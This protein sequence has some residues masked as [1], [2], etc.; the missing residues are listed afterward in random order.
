MARIVGE[1]QPTYVWVENSPILVVRGLERVLWDLAALGYDARWGIVSAENAGAPHKRERCWIMAYAKG[2]S[3]NGCS[4]SKDSRGDSN[5]KDI[6]GEWNN[7]RTVF[8]AD[9]L[10]FVSPAK[11]KGKSESGLCL[12][13]DGVAGQ[14]DQLRAIG[15]GQVPAVVR[16]AWNTLAGVE[17]PNKQ[18]G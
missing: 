13:V 11:A 4:G 5:R 10:D 6:P 17:M 2:E 8:G 1:V 12:V 9:Y 16:L 15:N 7:A 18:E 14:V 3:F